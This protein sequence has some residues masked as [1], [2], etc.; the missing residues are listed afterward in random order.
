MSL[1]RA[2]AT[3]VRLRTY[4]DRPAS[5]TRLPR[6]ADLNPFSPAPAPEARVY[7]I[8]QYRVLLLGNSAWKCVCHEFASATTCRHT[9]EAAGMREAQALIRTRVKSGTSGLRSHGRRK[10]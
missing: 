6:G 3:S 4:S 1:P 2:K 5:H 9:R 8:D 10:G 7:Q